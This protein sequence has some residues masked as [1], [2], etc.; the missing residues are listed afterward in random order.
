MTILHLK[1]AEFSFILEIILDFS[2]MQN[3]EKEIMI[4]TMN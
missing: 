2:N 4:G 1:K 3:S